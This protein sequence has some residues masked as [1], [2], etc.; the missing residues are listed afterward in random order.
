[1]KLQIRHFKEADLE[2]LLKSWDSAT[3]LAHPFLPV[4]F[5]SQERKNIPELYI[6]NTDTW[7]VVDNDI[8]VGFIALMGNEVGGLFVDTKYHGKGYGK[9]LM[10]KAQSLHSTLELDVFKKNT[11]GQNFYKKYGFTILEEKFHEPTGEMLLRLI[12]NK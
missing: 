7:V 6:P 4:D 3:K 9:A 10:D 2:Q 11:I 12:F 1:M 5:I 8:V